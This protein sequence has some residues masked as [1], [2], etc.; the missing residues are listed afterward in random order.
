MS[1]QQTKE[2][3]I[4]KNPVLEALRSD[5]AIHK[6]WLAEGLHK[7]A[8]APILVKAKE[9]G[10]PVQY[11]HRKK[12]DRIADSGNHQGVVAQIA[13]YDYVDLRDLLA[14]AKARGEA[15]FLL[16]LDEIE[17]P[18]NLG[19]I[20]RSADA[21]GAH[22]VIVPKR[23]AAGLTAAV[24]K[25]SAGA[26]EYVPVARVANIARTLDELKE[27]GIWVAGTDASADTDY[28]QADYKLPIAVVIGSEGKGISRLVR[29]KCDFVVKLPMRGSV[30]SLN[31]AVA[32][33]LLLFEVY[34]QRCPLPQ[35]AGSHG[36]DLDR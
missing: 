21:A 12:L 4:G 36:R 16:V 24:A 25:A 7:S 23:R 34:R 2:H 1:E 10:I 19:S 14:R 31:A 26:V 8:V 27:E 29:E 6:I 11:V 18:H 5:R 3:I 30:S 28:R 13:A 15:P 22:G 35:Q 32:A 9:R 17:D 33:A 20:L